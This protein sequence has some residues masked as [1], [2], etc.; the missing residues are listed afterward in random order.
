M[1][2]MRPATRPSRDVR[3]SLSVRSSSGARFLDGGGGRSLET[4]VHIGRMHGSPDT[5]D[6]R[7]PHQRF[8]TESFRKQLLLLRVKPQPLARAQ[9][10]LTHR[11]GYADARAA[12]DERER[13]LEAHAMS[14]RDDDRFECGRTLCRLACAQEGAPH[15]SRLADEVGMVETRMQ[16]RADAL[17][18]LLSQAVDVMKRLP[19]ADC[20]ADEGQGEGR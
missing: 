18:S 15:C 10:G 4:V 7:E 6:H 16:L 14:D 17:H 5:A 11:L 13:R 1:E 8:Q 12:P 9:V 19:D 3:G 20:A 2:T